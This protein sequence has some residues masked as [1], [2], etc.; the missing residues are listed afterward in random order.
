MKT[1][2]TAFKHIVNQ[3][4]FMSLSRNKLYRI[5][6]EYFGYSHDD[7]DYLVAVIRDY[8]ALVI[9]E[10]AAIELLESR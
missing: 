4:D 3:S 2:V 1:L 10:D 6:D 7:L 8:R 9:F 5:A